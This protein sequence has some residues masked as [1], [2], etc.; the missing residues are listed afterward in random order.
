M[1]GQITLTI[2]F[3]FLETFFNGSFVWDSY[4]TAN[5]P[6]KMKQNKI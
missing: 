5:G 2:F 1:I 4:P 6:V 3:T